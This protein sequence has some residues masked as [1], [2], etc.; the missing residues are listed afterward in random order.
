MERAERSKQEFDLMFDMARRFAR[1]YGDIGYM[2]FEDVAHDAAIKLLNRRGD[3]RP[4]TGWLYKTVR[5]AA[6]DAARGIARER[7]F[8]T[9]RFDG[10]PGCVCERADDLGNVYLNGRHG[11]VDIRDREADVVPQLMSMLQQLT[12]PL[13]QVLLLYAAGM[14]YEQIA[15]AT[16]AKTGTVR[17]RL[18]YARMRAKELLGSEL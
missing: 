15:A 18:H 5:S 6:A 3:R 11:A 2:S 4:T 9:T 7:T 13:R 16:G 14:K 12:E 17:S 1:K 10:S 8:V